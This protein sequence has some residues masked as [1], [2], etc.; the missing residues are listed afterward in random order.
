MEGS[1]GR[2]WQQVR[3][4]RIPSRI[5]T[6][7]S[8]DGSRTWK[9][10]RWQPSASSLLVGRVDRNPMT[11]PQRR[12]GTSP[13]SIATSVDLLTGGD[14]TW[15]VR[16]VS[17]EETRVQTLA[18]SRIADLV[19][20]LRAMSS[21]LRNRSGIGCGGGKAFG[22]WFE[23]DLEPHTAGKPRG[24]GRRWMVT[25]GCPR[26]NPRMHDGRRSA[27]ERFT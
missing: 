19:E 2:T 23:R 7:R 17:S 25:G 13:G 26:S 24:V 15:R 20:A 16:R 14:S 18:T 8:R 9:P 12:E 21:V 22:G 1:G 10:D 11:H 3:S 5:K 4:L 27:V 6:L